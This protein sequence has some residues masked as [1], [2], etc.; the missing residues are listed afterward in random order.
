M[1]KD[2]CFYLCTFTDD[3]N[4]LDDTVLIQVRIFLTRAKAIEERDTAVR[5]PKNVLGDHDYYFHVTN[6][7]IGRMLVEQNPKAKKIFNW[8]IKA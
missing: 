8:E 4:A 1:S 5:V 3:N 7:T 6:A 2:S